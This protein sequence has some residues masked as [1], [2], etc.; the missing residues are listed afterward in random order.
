MHWSR[1]VR[2]GPPSPDIDRGT[3]RCHPRS[4]GAGVTT[5]S[6]SKESGAR[7]TGRSDRG[8][9]VRSVVDE[10]S[11]RRALTGC[12]QRLQVGARRLWGTGASSDQGR[13]SGTS[14][15]FGSLA[16][17][18]LLSPRG[19]NPT[20]G[21][22][23]LGPRRWVLVV[24]VVGIPEE[25]GCV[26]EAHGGNRGRRGIGLE[27]GPRTRPHAGCP[28]GAA[29]AERWLLG[30]ERIDQAPSTIRAVAAPAFTGGWLL[31]MAQAVIHVPV[32]LRSDEVVRTFGTESTKV[33]HH[34]GS[35]PKM[36]QMAPSASE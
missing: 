1:T 27:C 26:A 11:Q 9:G 14:S 36:G 15:G 18:T 20:G 19:A 3:K 7:H 35:G 4:E 31:H 21:G 16:L 29:H 23:T 24:V 10:A 12:E 13:F 25:S 22:S 28:Q 33:K 6:R 17:R 2:P 8:S 34:S 5:N 30:A 32:S